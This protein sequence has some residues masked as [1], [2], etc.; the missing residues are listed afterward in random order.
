MYHPVLSQTRI[1]SLPSNS[2]TD[3]ISATITAAPVAN[4][5]DVAAV[6]ASDYSIIIETHNVVVPNKASL[7]T[8]TNAV[9]KRAIPTPASITNWEAASISSACSQVATGTITATTTDTTIV[10]TTITQTVTETVAVSTTTTATAT[11]TVPG[12]VLSSPTA[13]VGSLSGAA[14]S[15]DDYYYTLTLPFAIGAYG[16]SSTEVSLSIN[17]RICLGAADS[18]DWSNQPLPDSQLVPNTCVLAYFDDLYIYTD[19]Q[20]GIYYDISGAVGAR[21]VVFEYYVSH[22]AAPAEYYHFTVAFYEAL[23]GVVDVKYYSVSDRGASATV[24]IQDR[25]S[26]HFMQFEYNTPGSVVAGL[27]LRMDST[28]GTF[29]RG[30]FV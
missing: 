29:T 7:Q 6:D 19:T 14:S 5:R 1:A 3:E 17:G 8:T 28:T 18:A 20:Q 24:G 21:E 27:A 11:F 30:T 2:Q 22:F 16:Q 9:A 15:Y 13:I 10:P 12:V 26:G 4:K 23:P 25:V